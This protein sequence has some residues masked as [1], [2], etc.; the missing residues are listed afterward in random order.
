MLHQRDNM[1][2]YYGHNNVSGD[3]FQDIA[4]IIKHKIHDLM[5]DPLVHIVD[6]SENHVGHKG[7]TGYIVSHLKVT[8]V[9]DYFSGMQK[10]SRQRLM[11]K[12]LE[13][14]IKMLHSITFVLLTN[15]E[16]SS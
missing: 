13:T 7:R 10:L 12:I 15:T 1:S 3:A 2:D 11:H 4:A 14:E 9:S 8:I 6:E 16:A 5:K